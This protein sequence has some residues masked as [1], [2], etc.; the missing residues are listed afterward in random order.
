MRLR[1]STYFSPSKY[2][3]VPRLIDAWID[4]VV[5]I[6]VSIVVG[7]AVGLI[8]IPK[9]GEVDNLINTLSAKTMV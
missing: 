9:P 4:I 5:V 6:R 3:L 7:V 1:N 2:P 8:R